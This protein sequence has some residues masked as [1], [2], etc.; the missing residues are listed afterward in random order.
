MERSVV[1][2]SEV[3]MQ[4]IREQW[5][6]AGHRLTNAFEES[7]RAEVEQDGLFVTKLHIIGRAYGV[8]MSRGVS[9]ENI[10]FPFARARITGIKSWVQ[11]RLGIS[12]E[13]E[14]TSMAYAIATTHSRQGMP[15]REG[16]LGSRFLLKTKEQHQQKITEAVKKHFD[17]IIQKT[18][19]HGSNGN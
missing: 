3:V 2:I 7:L 15:I 13:R 14:A 6:I 4:A 1:H 5:V 17:L 9:P 19:D 11:M 12:D 16:Q 10:R 8:Y 18:I